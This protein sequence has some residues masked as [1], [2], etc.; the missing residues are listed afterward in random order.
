MGTTSVVVDR[1]N[2]TAQGFGAKSA[3]I[4]IHE[5]AHIGKEKRHVG[6]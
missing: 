3:P 6:R 1:L 2:D 5:N 4:P